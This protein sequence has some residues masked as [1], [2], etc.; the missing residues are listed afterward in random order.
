MTLTGKVL[1]ATAMMLAVA[2]LA[3]AHELECEKTVNGETLLELS[4]FPATLDYLL[5][6]RNIHPESA[7]TVTDASDPLLEGEGW[8]GF[9]D[10]LVI[11]FGD[12]ADDTFSIELETFEDCLSLATNDGTSDAFI[13]NTFTVEWDD[14]S[15]VCAARVH[16]VET[17][18]E[19]SGQRMTGGGSV[20]GTG[21]DRITHGFQIRCDANDPR[22]NLEINWP[23]E[24]GPQN[25]FHL[26]DLT[27][28]V[29]SDDPGLDEEN[30]VAGFDTFVGEGTGRHN[31]V[32]GATVE[33]TF[34]DN[35][36]PGSTDTAH[37][38][39]RDDGGV[40]VLDVDGDL[41]F[42]NHQAHP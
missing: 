31:G 34:T 30:P 20:F 41:N 4:E 8:T 7:S 37:I 25:T 16:C 13:D 3:N 14:G 21:R 40:V 11:P 35:G 38:V 1:G 22:Q 6:I 26:L 12:E 2:P 5:T 28:A 17:P 24:E 23:S 42:G 29:C 18:E 19:V 39:V 36:E 10:N 15:S 32:D 33:F 9:P 27:S